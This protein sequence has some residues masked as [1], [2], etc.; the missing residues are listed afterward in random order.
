[1][2]EK[3]LMPLAGELVEEVAECS[4]LELA[5]MSG[6]PAEVLM[7]YVEVGLIEPMRG[8]A[9]REWRFSGAA[10]ARLH[11]ARR[12]RRDFS[13]EPDA[14]ALVLDLLEEIE[15]LRAHVAVLE[16]AGGG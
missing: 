13:L 5:E 3:Y 15:R 6:L 4:L 7:E 1:M 10:L 2:S 8:G 12:L 11:R 16:R 9:A 14:L